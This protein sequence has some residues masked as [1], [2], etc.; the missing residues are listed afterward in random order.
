MEV[1]LGVGC[2][3]TS[4]KATGESICLDGEN[5][6]TT[7]QRGAEVGK[8]MRPNYNLKSVNPVVSGLPLI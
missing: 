3:K 6:A 7:T 4:S 8:G 5:D 1:E 2:W